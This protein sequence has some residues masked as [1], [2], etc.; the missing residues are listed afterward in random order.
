MSSPGTSDQCDDLRSIV[1]AFAVLSGRYATELQ[2]TASA[3][4][5]SPQMAVALLHLSSVGETRMSEFARTMACD[6]GN[7]SGTIDRLEEAEL[8]VRTANALDKRVRIARTTPEGRRVATKLK[9]DLDG[10]GVIAALRDLD[11][12]ERRALRDTLGRLCGAGHE[13]PARA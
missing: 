3:H 1:A 7:L 12:R 5:L 6:A 8:V 4:G 9:R 10:T 13:A 11:D 2:A